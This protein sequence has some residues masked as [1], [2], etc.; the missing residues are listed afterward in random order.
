[1]LSNSPSPLRFRRPPANRIPRPAPAA[2]SPTGSGASGLPS[3][4]QEQ[5]PADP[6]QA[7]RGPA[8]PL[9]RAWPPAD[10][11]S[12]CHQH[13]GDP[14]DMHPFT[15]TTPWRPAARLGRAD[16][17]CAERAVNYSPRPA[18][19]PGSPSFGQLPASQPAG[20]QAASESAPPRQSP[21]DHRRPAHPAARPPAASVQ[22]ARPKPTHLLDDRDT[23]PQEALR[24]C[25][26]RG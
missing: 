6:W 8:S 15:S 21:G 10:F 4:G 25:E 18:P 3:S 24:P 13:G 7:P 19:R 14:R 5:R 20:P 9:Y 2:E 16:L 12:I 17:S 23:E 1:M 11:F 26:G 22:P